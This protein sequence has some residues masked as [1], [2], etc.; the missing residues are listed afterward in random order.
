MF[1]LHYITLHYITLH[2]IIS[3]AMK[4]IITNHTGSRYAHSN[5][6]ESSSILSLT[7]L[8][9]HLPT[10]LQPKDP[11]G[12]CN[13]IITDGEMDARGGWAAPPPPTLFFTFSAK[14]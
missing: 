8:L 5:N 12:A 4:F 9:R 3:A 6:H 11:H 13:S 7:H 10:Y 14:E 1:T 2:Y